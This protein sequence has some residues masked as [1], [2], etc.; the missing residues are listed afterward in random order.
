MTKG[1]QSLENVTSDALV[2]AFSI[3]GTPDECR[4]QYLAYKEVISHVILHTPYMPPIAREDS[5]DA[6][7]NIVRTFTR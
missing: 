5:Q 3:S 4:E 2:K 6:F 7:R 1:P